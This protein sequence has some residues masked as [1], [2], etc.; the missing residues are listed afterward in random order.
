MKNK[1]LF[2]APFLLIFFVVGI[3]LLQKE[4]PKKPQIL[5]TKTQKIVKNKP[6]TVSEK[7]RRFFT[8]LVPPIEQIYSQL[9]QEYL[10]IKTLIEKTPQDPKIQIC[11]QSY[12]AKDFEDLLRRMKPH[13]KSI[14]LAQAAMESAWGTSRFFKIANNVFGVWSFKE[15]EPRVAAGKKRG[16][17]TIYLKEYT[18]ITDAV[19]DYYKILAVGKA[20]EEFR[21]EKMK[22]DDPYILVNYLDKYSERGNL[23]SQELASVIRHNNLIKYDK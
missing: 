10:E 1:L 22:T 11:M 2:A 14:A 4:E 5:P 16:N 18:S 7:K 17:Q 19:R 9:H 3:Y 15:N 12:A 21:V 13:P 6:I 20:F 23:Y 8:L